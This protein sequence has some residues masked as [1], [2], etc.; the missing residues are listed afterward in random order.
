MHAPAPKVEAKRK[1]GRGTGSVEKSS[2]AEGRVVGRKELWRGGS[3]VARAHRPRRTETTAARHATQRNATQR[4]ERRAAQ[5][6]VGEGAR[7]CYLFR[8]VH[9]KSILS[10]LLACWCPAHPERHGAAAPAA[11]VSS[12][13]VRS[14]AAHR[15][16]RPSQP[17]R[18]ILS[19]SPIISSD[20]SSHL[21]SPFPSL[22]PHPP[23]RLPMPVLLPSRTILHQGRGQ[24]DCTSSAGGGRTATER[25]GDRS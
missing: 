9:G 8:R 2:E 16:P 4:M 5:I 21:L 10:P 12:R 15:L 7:S 1:K 3:R 25:S 18:V 11:L 24:G 14:P 13:L 22:S 23:L 20:P 19:L 17:R 6:G